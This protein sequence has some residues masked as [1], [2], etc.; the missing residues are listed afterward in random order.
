L[1]E[2]TSQGTDKSIYGK[3]KTW[4][5]FTHQVLKAVNFDVDNAVFSFI[6]NTARVLLWPH[7]GLR[8]IST[9]LNGFYY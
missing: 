2:Y 7:K 4:R 3:E 8:T 9:S 1:K 6:P 5:T